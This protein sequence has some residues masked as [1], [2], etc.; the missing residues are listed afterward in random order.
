MFLKA[1]RMIQRH[2]MSAYAVMSHVLIKMHVL[3][4]KVMLNVMTNSFFPEKCKNKI[5][6]VKNVK[7]FI[8]FSSIYVA[9][10]TSGFTEHHQVLTL[11]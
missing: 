9:A 8:V 2:K 7:N 3:A 6:E 11:N 10:N 1:K 5:I 4:W